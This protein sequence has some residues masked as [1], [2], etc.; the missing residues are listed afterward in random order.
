MQGK[1]PLPDLVVEGTS[2]QTIVGSQLRVLKCG[3]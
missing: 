1:G 3:S 2:A